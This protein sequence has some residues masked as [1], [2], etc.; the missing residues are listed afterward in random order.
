MTNATHDA[1]GN[2][3]GLRAEVLDALRELLGVKGDTV[4]PLSSN[5]ALLGC[6]T[7]EQYP[8]QSAAD[9][10]DTEP[11]DDSEMPFASPNIG[12]ANPVTLSRRDN[13][14]SADPETATP[15]AVV[16]VRLERARGFWDDPRQ[17]YHIIRGVSM[18][19][20]QAVAV[21]L[22][23]RQMLKTKSTKW[24]TVVCFG[25][26]N[27]GVV[28][29]P[30]PVDWKPQRPTAWPWGAEVSV[31]AVRSAKHRNRGMATAPGEVLDYWLIAYRL[32]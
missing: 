11:A 13:V 4:S 24:H 25:N 10:S 28:K 2:G 17:R 21:N 22:N 30:V 6:S 29:V 12:N 31:K 3:T 16:H 27:F 26:D 18:D 7:D 19:V 32:K 5:T 8:D 20:A 23:L 15:T 14:D 1:N 9:E